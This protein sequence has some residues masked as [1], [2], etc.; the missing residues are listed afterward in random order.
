MT[1]KKLPKVLIIHLNRF[2]ADGDKKVKN[3]EPI[4]YEE[5]EIF[6]GKK[7]RLLSVIVHEGST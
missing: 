5:Y 6:Y 2:K 4:E 7:Y 1:I 3:S